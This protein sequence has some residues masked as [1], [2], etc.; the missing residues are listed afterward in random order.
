MRAIGVIDKVQEPAKALVEHF[1]GGCGNPHDVGILPR[2][3]GSKTPGNL[4]E[5]QTTGIFRMSLDVV[6]CLYRGHQNAEDDTRRAENVH[7]RSSRV[8]HS[9]ITATSALRKVGHRT[10]KFLFE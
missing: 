1:D 8:L 4:V 2:A 6:E 10:D 5:P 9:E 3:K 7:Q